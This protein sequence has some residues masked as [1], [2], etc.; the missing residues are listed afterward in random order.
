MKKIIYLFVLVILSSG[1]ASRSEFIKTGEDSYKFSR[2]TMNGFS[3]TYANKCRTLSES[4]Q[5][6][7]DKGKVM[8]VISIK[9]YRDFN[10]PK[11][12]IQFMCLDANDLKLRKDNEEV[13]VQSGEDL[14]TKIK[15]LDKLL[16]DGLITKSEFEEQKKKLLNDYT[17]K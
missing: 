13:N 2:T 15:T 8:Q 6:C 1:C 12:D 11:A 16:S 10:C 4:K 14:A 9:D 5:F 3:T 7:E 17:N